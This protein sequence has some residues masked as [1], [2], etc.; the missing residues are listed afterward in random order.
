MAGMFSSDWRLPA[1]TMREAAQL[2]VDWL[3]HDCAAPDV[4]VEREMSF[5]ALFARW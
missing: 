2:L 1:V 4:L 5:R 3:E